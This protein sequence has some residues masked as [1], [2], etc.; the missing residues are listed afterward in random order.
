MTVE[1]SFESLVRQHTRIKPA[2]ANAVWEAFMKWAFFIFESERHIIFGRLG[3]LGYKIEEK[4][5]RKIPFLFLSENFIKKYGLAAKY[6]SFVLKPVVKLNPSAI[7][8]HN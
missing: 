8:K 4:N 1:Y 6:P 2:L 5:S 3:N 7:V